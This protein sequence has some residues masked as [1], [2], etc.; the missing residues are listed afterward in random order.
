MLS[1]QHATP[2]PVQILLFELGAVVSFLVVETSATNLYR[3]SL[4]GDP[5]S[6][7]RPT[8]PSSISTVTVSPA[9]IKV[10]VMD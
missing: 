10:Q 4:G 7:V 9:Q 5:E 8:G 6:G 2:D 1:A 3:R